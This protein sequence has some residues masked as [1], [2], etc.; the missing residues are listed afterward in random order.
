MMY[1]V[2]LKEKKFRFVPKKNYSN[3]ELVARRQAI[4]PIPPRLIRSARYDS[5]RTQVYAYVAVN[6][7]SLCKKTVTTDRR[8]DLFG[9]LVRSPK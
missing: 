9:A 8:R 1:E 5:S 4:R 3:L 2:R 6:G 7:S